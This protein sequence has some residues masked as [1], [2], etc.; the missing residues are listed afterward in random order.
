MK[1]IFKLLALFLLFFVSSQS[2]AQKNEKVIYDIVDTP[3]QFTNGDS[4]MYEYLANEIIYPKKAKRKK[5]Q[6]KVYVQFVVSKD[7][8]IQDVKVIKGK[9]KILNKE[10][11]RVIKKMPKWKPGEQE[12]KQVSVRYTIPINFTIN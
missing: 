1:T 10:A 4:A 7:G 9:Y 2:F 5:I 3:P 11:L 12:G 8:S 6:D